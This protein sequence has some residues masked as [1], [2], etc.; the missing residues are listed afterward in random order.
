M[1]VD[2]KQEVDSFD[3]EQLDFRTVAQYSYMNPGDMKYIYLYHHVRYTIRNCLTLFLSI[4][5][6]QL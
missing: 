2:C 5:S 4:A 3:V 6:L 1:C